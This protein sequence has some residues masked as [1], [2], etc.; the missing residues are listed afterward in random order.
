[1][2]KRVATST[3]QK[4]MYRTIKETCLTAN[5]L[6]LLLHIFY[7][8]LFIVAKFDILIYLDAAYIALYL[9]FFLIIFKKKYYLYALCC[10]NVF[11]AFIIV[12]TIMMGFGSGFGFYLIGLC[13]V[14]FFTTYFSKNRN[15]KGSIVWVGLSIAIY[16]TI[17]FVTQFN[18]P[19]Y[20]TPRWLEMT[21]FTIH[22]VLAFVFVASYLVVFLKYAFSLEKKIMNESRTDELTQINNRYSLYDYF[23]QE[24]DKSN[25]SL[26]IF[27]IDDFKNINDGYGHVTGDYVLKTVAEIINN[28]L[29]D[30]FVC[31]YGGEEFIVVL[32]KNVAYKKLEEIRKTIEKTTFEFNNNKI[33]ITTTIG[34]AEYINGISLE[35]WIENADK[36]MYSGK[37]S[38][39]N[40]TVA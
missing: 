7:L 25:L 20:L 39:K 33:N 1:M 3:D 27:D 4:N 30:S 36:K 14:S 37:N 12:C 22:S 13:V 19:R 38:G 34:I 32:N 26:A 16:L 21:L 11:F 10:G 29:S 18:T 17:Y 23:D 2:N 6:Y 28:Q 15:I 35:K 8:I 31:R 5:V 24:K 40:K 9:L